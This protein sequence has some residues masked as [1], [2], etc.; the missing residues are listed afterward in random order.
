MFLTLGRGWAAANVLGADPEVDTEPS[1]MAEIFQR[2]LDL[3][4]HRSVRRLS[5]R[6]WREAK[7]T[8]AQKPREENI[9]KPRKATHAHRLGHRE[10]TR[11]LRQHKPWKPERVRMARKVSK[12][13][14]KSPPRVGYEE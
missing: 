6:G 7:T 5:L 2:A 10:G 8:T 13:S 14:R 11:N 1:K 3:G 4:D 12:E 9:S